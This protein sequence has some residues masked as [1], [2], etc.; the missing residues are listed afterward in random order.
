MD[1]RPSG[2]RPR[3]IFSVIIP[4][5]YHRGQWRQCVAAWT[6]Q[7][8]AAADFE[9]I[10]AVPSGFS[11]ADRQDLAAALRPH[12]RIIDGASAH[13][14][15]LS[16]IGA[17]L[18][19]GRFLFFTESHCWPE[20]DALTICAQ[21]FAQRPDWAGFSCQSLRVV[22]SR[23]AEAEADMY[24]GDI[25]R[26]MS[27]HP[28]L[29][30]LDQCFATRREAYHACGGLQPELGH[31]AEW[32]LAANYH[33]RDLTIGFQPQAKFHHYY[34]GKTHELVVF[35][36]DF[37]EGEIS[38]LNAPSDGRVRQLLDLPYEW[39]CQGNWNASAWLRLARIALRHRQA[40]RPPGGSMSHRTAV[41]VKYAG[42]A[43]RAATDAALL[44]PCE[45]LWARV[46][47]IAATRLS[48]RD[49]RARAFRA[50]I[51]ACIR[52][53]RL[54]HI[55]ARP[56]PCAASGFDAMAPGN[57]G[58]YPIESCEGRPMRWSESHAL[59]RGRL[60]A[61][62]HRIAIQCAP[63]R[64]PGMAAL[65]VYFNGRSVANADTAITDESIRITVD[66]RRTG[67]CSLA[68]ICI[69]PMTA[70]D[71]RP[72]GLPVMAVEVVASEAATSATTLM[73]ALVG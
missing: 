7:Q 40:D 32:V 64:A 21:T 14:M 59:L 46:K 66:Q 18:A 26:G 42:R 72:V 23:T 60:S 19:A 68:L 33:V 50:Y 69:D 67:A 31:F 12:D 36:R 55:K 41:A 15:G 29:K 53:H 11:A 38:Y 1:G 28:W 6:R 62:R 44:A 3:V 20:A 35:T 30:I 22:T 70:P 51:A 17:R 47:F 10:L 54:R 16:A 56:A 37:V 9:L 27:V 58:F 43:L 45:E 24:E 73:R 65:G 39:I 49:D 71:G 13:D 61:G 52:A 48:D 5:E 2:P 4:L 34:V 63:L 57:T 8:F 25:A